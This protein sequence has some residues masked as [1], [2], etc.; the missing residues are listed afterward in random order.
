MTEYFGRFV[1]S[2]VGDTRGS[3][4]LVVPPEELNVSLGRNRNLLNSPNLQLSSHS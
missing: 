2:I 3:Y 1:D 4:S